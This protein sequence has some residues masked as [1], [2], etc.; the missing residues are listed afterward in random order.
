MP[1]KL[2]DV[3]KGNV[4]Q[5]V[6]QSLFEK[7]GYRVAHLGIEELLRE[8]K[9]L[10]EK[11]YRALA[12]PENLRA[13]PDFLVTDKTL[14]QAFLV[15][16]KFRKNVNSLDDPFCRRI[17][18]QQRIWP[19]M[20]VVVLLGESPQ[21][22]GKFLQDYVR[23]IPPKMS[24]HLI[25]DPSQNALQRWEQLFQLSR[26]F[27]LFNSMNYSELDQAIATLRQLTDV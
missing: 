5:T 14:S 2:R 19:G 3:L 17:E 21:P 4:A 16:I 15:E 9:L 1:I 6:A 10:D 8:V 11:Q 13:L 23:I 18:W 22:K 26:C 20:Y 27:E 7:A 24:V 12:L 25:S